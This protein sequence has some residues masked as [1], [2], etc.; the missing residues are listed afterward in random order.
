MKLTAIIGRAGSGKSRFLFEE[1][2]DNIHRG[3]PRRINFLVPEQAT[4]LTERR[5]LSPPDIDGCFRTGVLSF[6]RLFAQLNHDEG[7]RIID[8]VE[9]R[10]LLTA[11]MRNP[12]FSIEP[13]GTIRNRPGFIASLSEQLKILK[14]AQATSVE[15]GDIELSETGFT[16][17]KLAFLERIYKAY[18]DALSTG[19]L[20]DAEDCLSELAVMAKGEKSLE[21]VTWFIDGF[22]GFTRQEK[23]ALGGIL[24]NAEGAKVGLCL[25]PDAIHSGL[26]YSREMFSG[27][28]QT[29]EWFR[30]Y[31]ESNG[32]EFNIKEIGVKGEFKRFA[33]PSIA[34]LEVNLFSRVK[35]AA[36]PSGVYFIPAS[37]NRAAARIIAYEI[38]RL[39]FSG[40]RYRDIVVVLRGFGAIA[41]YLI[42]A[43]DIAGIPHFLDR[44]KP[45]RGHPLARLI[46]SAWDVVLK[47]FH[48]DAFLA[49][50]RCGLVPIPNVE[51]D[52]LEN[53]ILEYGLTFDF[54]YREWLSPAAEARYSGKRERRREKLR[55]AAMDILAPLCSFNEQVNETYRNKGPISDYSR[56]TLQLIDGFKVKE[57]LSEDA[58]ILGLSSDDEKRAYETITEIL[59]RIQAV[60]GDEYIAPADY[61]I[62]LRSTLDILSTGRI[63][64]ALDA[65]VIGEVHRSRVEEAGAV[66]ICGLEEGAFPKYPFG[67]GLFDE[68]EL[69]GLTERFP[70]W[71]TDYK[72][73][74]AEEE[75]LF[76]IAC[77]RA[78]EKLYLIFPAEDEQGGAPSPFVGE[79]KRALGIKPDDSAIRVHNQPMPLNANEIAGWIDTA[80]S[81]G[82]A[83]TKELGA[84]G[85]VQSRLA[86][87]NRLQFIFSSLTYS[88]EP[89]LGETE[90]SARAGGLNKLDATRLRTFGNCPFQYFARY[91]LSLELRLISEVTRLELGSFVHR[92]LESCF[93]R[94]FAP[95]ADPELDDAEGLAGEAVG[96]A[97][98]LAETFRDGVLIRNP[99]EKALLETKV[100]PLIYAFMTQEIRRLAAI[101]FRPRYFEWRFGVEDKPG[102][103][104]L[105]PGGG[106]V[107]LTGALDRIDMGTSP[108]MD[109]AIAL[110]YKLSSEKAG[111]PQLMRI[112]LETQ[113]PIYLK[114]LSDLVG[115]KPLAGLFLYLEKRTTDDPRKAANDFTRRGIYLKGSLPEDMLALRS[116]SKDGVDEK[117]FNA[118][119]DAAFE[120]IGK[121]ARRLLDGE[122]NVKPYI[123][124]KTR[125]CTHCDY[126]DLCRFDLTVNSYRHPEREP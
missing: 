81:E 52:R 115:Y 103:K 18:N 39:V 91:D 100:Y 77:T 44:R 82:N 9:K 35:S 114:V 69:R 57:R 66:F 122:I 107:E 14:R 70:D 1:A 108:E 8:E 88:N 113:L 102:V 78:K 24:C 59:G 45:I 40:L 58:A 101:P 60:L 111:L 84:Y 41:D 94:W 43:F 90:R 76:Y 119:L 96:Y 74:Q 17:A 116:R 42:E 106:E 97:R 63:P 93:K 32:F 118:T 37:D 98:T 95:G 4:H 92:V 22:S 7:P 120:R 13:F 25:D 79:A 67:A 51:I 83:G 123:Y 109:G 112:G 10:L 99:L 89:C 5:L 71:A 26:E 36:D 124:N 65:V 16:G 27:N 21:G 105:I 121:Y 53:Y 64:P 73:I 61:A 56:A 46:E 50:L 38:K 31:A 23:A 110:D 87:D 28:L 104:L 49:L 126:R 2:W 47:N 30:D 54:I 6:R 3:E 117:E 20:R 15:P 34:A 11:I 29:F 62:I 19:G 80:V 33:S 72:T 68:R 48:R 85:V 55:N 125:P 86:E 75:Y 12:D